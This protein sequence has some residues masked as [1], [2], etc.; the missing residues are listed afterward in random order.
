MITWLVN[1]LGIPSFSI[2][3]IFCVLIFGGAFYSGYHTHTIVYEAAQSRELKAEQIA[4]LSA[5]AKVAKA[6]ADYESLSSNTNQTI[7]DL[8]KK[9]RNVKK[10][11]DTSCFDAASVLILQQGAAT[12]NSAR[13]FIATVPSTSTY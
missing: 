10:P 12:S 8:K 11:T 4:R 2:E 6:S 7:N 9:L 3:L 5:E 1:A 13:G